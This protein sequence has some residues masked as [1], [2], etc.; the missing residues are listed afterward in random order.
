VYTANFPLVGAPAFLPK[1][2]KGIV[3]ISSSEGAAKPVFSRD[4]CQNGMSSQE[5][6]HSDVLLCDFLP[7]E[8]D[9]PETLLQIILLNDVPAVPRKKLLKR[10]PT[11]LKYKGITSIFEE[12]LDAFISSYPC[13]LNLIHNNC[14]T[15]AEKLIDEL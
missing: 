3:L 14:Y 15:F 11:G 4:S 5:H 7:A 12:D 10:K 6:S 9:K 8:P 2:H 13:K 1:L